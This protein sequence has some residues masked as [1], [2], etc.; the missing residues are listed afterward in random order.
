MT[1][2]NAH[3]SRLREGGT[4]HGMWMMTTSTELARTSSALGFDYVCVDMQH[5]YARSSDVVRLSDA[6]RA[7]GNA[8]VVAR[9][10]DNRFTEIGM[11]A[12]AGVEAIIVPLVSSAD[13]ARA[14]VSAL[15]YPDEGGTRSYGP[16]HV[17][18]NGFDPD[19]LHTRPLLFVMIENA[20]GLAAVEEICAVEGVD[21]I[22]IGPSDLAYSL[23]SRPGPEEPV[24]TEAIARILAVV[25]EA[26]VIPGIHTGSGADAA[27]RRE[28]GF[29]F[30]TA[31]S[32]IGA[33]RAA[34]ETDLAA[35]QG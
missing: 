7:A 3:T 18:M 9:V 31:S 27:A 5:G 10:P 32:D 25:Q 33:A 26:G 6:V 4:L 12:D 21:G 29:R 20:E 23:G 24:T 16:T 30:V 15:R 2:P 34:Y 1:R 13:Q 22:Y 14:A 28:Q 17:M 8:M 11:L 19:P 35:T